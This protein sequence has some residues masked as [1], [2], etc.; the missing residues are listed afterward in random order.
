MLDVDY[1]L[2]ILCKHCEHREMHQLTKIYI[3]EVV[4]L[5]WP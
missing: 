1:N 5:V 3:Q 4:I 2:Y